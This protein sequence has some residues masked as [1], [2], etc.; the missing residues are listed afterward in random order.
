MQ[1]NLRETKASKIILVVAAFIVVVAGMRASTTILVPFLLAAVFTSSFLNRLLS[2][3][4]VK[5]FQVNVP[6]RL[7]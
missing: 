4:F 6:S 7:Q 3:L 2:V 1:K 5:Y